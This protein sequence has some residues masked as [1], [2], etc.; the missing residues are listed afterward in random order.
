MHTH[1]QMSQ[2]SDIKNRLKTTSIVFG[3][4]DC[5]KMLEILRNLNFINEN[6]LPQ[7]KTRVAR[8]LGGG[9][10]NLYLTELIMDNILDKLE[11]EEIVPVVSVFVAHA[12]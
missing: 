4:D 9:D 11:P 1:E 7:L 12:R 2:I 6:N 8:E 5:E 10:E 3:F